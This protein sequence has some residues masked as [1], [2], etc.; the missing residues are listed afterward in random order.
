MTNDNKTKGT[1]SLSLNLVAA[2]ERV[3]TLFIQSVLMQN[4]RVHRT[5]QQYDGLMACRFSYHM[6][7]LERGFGRA[8][9]F[10]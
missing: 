5:G 10:Y 4:D 6:I 8:N 1:C 2:V 7:W 9:T 3:D